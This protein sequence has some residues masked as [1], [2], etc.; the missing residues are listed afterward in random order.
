MT[1]TSRRPSASTNDRLSCRWLRS[2]AGLPLPPPRRRRLPLVRRRHHPRDLRPAPRTEFPRI[3]LVAPAAILHR[4][5]DQFARLSGF[6]PPVV[7]RMRER[8]SRRLDFR[9]EDLE[10]NT[11]APALDAPALVIHDEEDERVP[12]EDG[13]EL[14]RLLPRAELH[15][16]RG[17]GHSGALRDP[18]I[19]RRIAGF[20]RADLPLSADLEGPDEPGGRR[21]VPARTT[22]T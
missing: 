21:G 9:W 6:P 14:A 20:F 5:A 10:A 1:A 17:L 12:V 7:A 15:T 11:I 18:E 19:V 2:A 4:V 16:T 8:L 3:A 13:V 22:P